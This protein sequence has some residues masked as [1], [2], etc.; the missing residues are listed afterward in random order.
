MLDDTNYHYTVFLPTTTAF[1]ALIDD[2]GITNIDGFDDETLE[3]LLLLHIHKDGNLD[4]EDLEDRCSA[5]LLM[6]NGDNT[7]T[8]CSNPTDKQIFQKGGGNPSSEA[9]LVTSFDIHACNGIIHVLDGVILPGGFQC[10]SPTRKPTPAPTEH[11]L[12]AACSAHP[13]CSALAGDCCPTPDNTFLACCPDTHSPTR[14]PTPHPTVHPTSHP[15]NTPTSHPTSHPTN[16]PT[17]HPTR[18]P[19]KNPTK[20]PTRAPTNQPTPSP[21]THIEDA[22]CSAHPECAA[23]GLTGDCCPTDEDE[24]LDCCSATHLPTPSPTNKPPTPSPTNK[25]PTPS[26]TNKPTIDYSDSSCAAYPACSHLEGEC[27]P[28]DDGLKLDCCFEDSDD[29]VAPTSVPIDSCSAN[30]RCSALGLEGDCCPADDALKLDCCFDEVPGTCSQFTG[31]AEL[32]LEGDCCPAPNGINLACCDVELYGL[33]IVDSKYCDDA[34]DFSCYKFGKPE[35]CLK[36]SKVCPKEK[37]ECEVG[38]PIIGKSYCTYAPKFGCF[39]NGWPKCCSEDPAECPR[40]RPD[41]ELG[42]LFKTGSYC[43]DSPDFR[44]HELGYPPCCL[45]NDESC[46]YEE[47][48]CNIAEKGCDED[49]SILS[50]CKSKDKYSIADTRFGFDG[51]H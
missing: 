20:M 43:G 25:P 50:I 18:N 23:R 17:P 38:F 45:T 49:D 19:T 47:P 44:C 30:S 15:T 51:C 12:D 33:P 46:P 27:C 35:C 6:E 21:T 3:D 5:L 14:A 31:C 16:I 36:A 8:I 40:Y 2:C 4:K 32:G 39:E 37:P 10:P 26:P 7:R 13:A 34:L 11:L 22:A 24:R 1:H 28:T 41:C 48:E 9:P 42:T 29:Q